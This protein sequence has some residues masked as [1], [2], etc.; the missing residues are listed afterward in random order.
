VKIIDFSLVNDKDF[1]LES[2]LSIEY[3]ETE[4]ITRWTNLLLYVNGL[5]LE[6]IELKNATEKVK[7]G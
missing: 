3:Q 1:L 7:T 4:R 5:P 6:M 2:Q